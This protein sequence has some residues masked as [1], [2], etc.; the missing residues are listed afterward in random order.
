MGFFSDCVVVYAK[1]HKG[2]AKGAAKITL[3][4]DQE[5]LVNQYM[6]NVRPKIARSKSVPNLAFLG[7]SGGPLRNT[8]RLIKRV[9]EA[10][11]YPG[12]F[13]LTNVR[14]VVETKAFNTLDCEGQQ[15]VSSA[16][17]HTPSVAKRHYTALTADRAATCQQ[18]VANLLF[19]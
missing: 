16:L 17:N 8:S 14:K 4:R 15:M 10:S 19:K 6:E 12:R 5:Q 11:A 18:S 2:G 7:K 1:K 3:T 9:W 13:S